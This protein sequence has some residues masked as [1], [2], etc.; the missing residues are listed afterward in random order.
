MML[1]KIGA[2][3]ICAV[4][5]ASPLPT[6]PV[7]MKIIAAQKDRYKTTAY[8]PAK[9]GMEQLDAA[10]TEAKAAR[11]NL[12]VVLGGNWCHDSAAL[13]NDIAAAPLNQI[14]AT[15]LATVFIDV[16]RPKIPG[17]GRNLDVPRRFGIETLAGTPTVLVLSPDGKM[18]NSMDDAK[19]WRNAASRKPKD[20]EAFFRRYTAAS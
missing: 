1:W 17:K 10:L 16:G 19:S 13:A 20:V 8:D 2:S 14:F 4:A 3:I 18:L 11:R 15:K 5:L 12:V 9:K 7:Q 6:D